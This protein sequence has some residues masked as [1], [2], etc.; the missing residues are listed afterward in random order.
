MDGAQA[1]DGEGKKLG[2]F[3]ISITA[4]ELRLIHNAMD[5]YLA[6]RPKKKGLGKLFREFQGLNCR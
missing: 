2:K 4:D 5:E 3:L 1:Q 6:G